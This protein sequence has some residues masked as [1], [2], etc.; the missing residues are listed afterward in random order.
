MNKCFYN[1]GLNGIIFFD[2][3]RLN[4]IWTMN[5]YCK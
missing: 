4:K 5:I 2:D 3:R 1:S